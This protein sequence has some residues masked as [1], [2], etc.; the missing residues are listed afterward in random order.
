[1]GSVLALSSFYHPNIPSDPKNVLTK[2]S[3]FFCAETAHFTSNILKWTSLPE[4]L[5][6]TRTLLNCKSPWIIFVMISFDGFKGTL[7]VLSSLRWQESRPFVC[8]AFSNRS[9]VWKVLKTNLLFCLALGGKNKQRNNGPH[10]FL[11]GRYG[12]KVHIGV[13]YSWPLKSGSQKGVFGRGALWKR[14]LVKNAH[15]LEIPENWKRF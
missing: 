14:G 13:F 8:L 12:L 6:V 9:S 1:M 4:G 10:S 2:K 11:S 3:S 15:S 7:N 5:K